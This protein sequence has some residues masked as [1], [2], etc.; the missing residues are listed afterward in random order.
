MAQTRKTWRENVSGWDSFGD[1]RH[2]SYFR[3][4]TSSLGSDNVKSVGW[5]SEPPEGQPKLRQLQT[6]RTAILL[7]AR[8]GSYQSAWLVQ[9]LG[10][11]VDLS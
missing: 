1:R 8:R 5:L 9:A 10:G 3:G 4:D 6:V 11:K 2:A 7:H